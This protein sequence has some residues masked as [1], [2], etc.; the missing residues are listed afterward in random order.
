M[1]HLVNTAGPHRDAR[2]RGFSE[3]PPIGPVEV[4]VRLEKEPESVRIQPGN[5]PAECSWQEGL[6]TV[7]VERLALYDIVE[8]TEEK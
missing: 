8:I 7:R 1:V 5:R 2:E 3:I 6:L 4:Q